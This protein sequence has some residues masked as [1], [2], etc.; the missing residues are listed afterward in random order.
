MFQP[1]MCL[2]IRNHSFLH[3]KI[4][5]NKIRN[6]RMSIKKDY[7]LS[8]T[9]YFVNTVRW[10]TVVSNNFSV[11]MYVCVYCTIILFTVS[12]ELSF[13]VAFLWIIVEKAS[14]FDRDPNQFW[15]LA[16]AQRLIKNYI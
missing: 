4:T 8:E 16:I 10:I 14:H 7:Y 2:L 12:S 1:L 6:F 5:Q 15:N 3:F 13:N 9:N 11:C